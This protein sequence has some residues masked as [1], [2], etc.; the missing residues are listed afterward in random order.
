[1]LREVERKGE[2]KDRAK[3]EAGKQG[4]HKRINP[5]YLVYEDNSNRTQLFKTSHEV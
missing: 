3:Y 1:M 2:M 4:G 5:K